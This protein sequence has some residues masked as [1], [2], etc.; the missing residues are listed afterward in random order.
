MSRPES[1]ILSAEQ[2]RSLACVLDTLIPP[3][4]DGRMPGAGEIG[5]AIAI[6]EAMASQPDLQ[7][8]V[9]HGLAGFEELIAGIGLPAFAALPVA[10]RAELLDE[11]L[12]SQPAFVASLVFHAYTAYYR[13]AKVM[14]ALGLEA[15]PPH[16]KG[17]EMAPTDTSLL[18]EMRKRKPMYREC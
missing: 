2:T 6:E 1:T 4:A 5:L 9:V 8:A 10:E 18:D 7:P 12:P 3:S 11:L 16:P 13:H 15:R 14:V 17:Y